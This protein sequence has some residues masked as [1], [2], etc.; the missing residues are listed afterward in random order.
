MTLSWGQTLLVVL[1]VAAAVLGAGLIVIL[2]R[3]TGP[4][5]DG[6]SVVR[7]WIAIS[8]VLGL[9][10]FTAFTFAVND[11][12]LRSALIG[13]LTASVGSAIAYYFSAK[14]SDQARQDLLNATIG[15]EAVPDLTGLDESQA[16]TA[17]G[18]TSLKLEVD[19]ATPPDGRRVAQQNPPPGTQSPKGTSVV[20][21]FGP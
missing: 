19:P 21:R 3:A 16:A 14:S 18:K 5:A 13:G 8:L 17:L 15:T 7:S 11:T 4:G 12:S 2:A 6:G 20:V 9:V 1:I 10:M